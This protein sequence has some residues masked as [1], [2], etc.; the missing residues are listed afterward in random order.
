MSERVAVAE[1]SAEAASPLDAIVKT[2]AQRMLQA[3]LEVEVDEYVARHTD[4]VDEQGHRQVVRNGRLPKRQIQTGA[5]AIDVEQPR[6]RD[7]R[8]AGGQDA[9]RFSSSI[10]PPYLRK[11]KVVEDL[12]P[13]LY[14]RGISAGDMQAAL[15]ALV[16]PDAPG[17]SHN[18]VMT[19]S[20][21][22]VERT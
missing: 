10:L 5:G 14:L 6:V 9:V 2:G 16:G 20:C 21:V 18:G 22:S 19:R 11:S 4:V 1:V 12:I 7:R 15:E 17:L 13:W 3:A 8:G